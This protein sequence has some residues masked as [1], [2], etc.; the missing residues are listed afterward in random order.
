MEDAAKS[1][2][3]IIFFLFK[4]GVKPSEIVQRLQGVFGESAESKSTVYLW[5]NR[6]KAGRTSLEDDPRSGRP[7]TSVNDRTVVAVE[8]LLKADRRITIREISVSVGIG[9]RQVH[10][11]LHERL[12]V[13]KVSARWVPRL[14]GPEQKLNRSDTCR[15]LQEL[16]ARYGDR[17]WQR[18]ITTD[19]TWIPFF[20]PETKTQSKEWRKPDEGPPLKARAV[21]S[22][23]KV[24]LTVFWDCEGIIC[25]DYLPK[26]TTINAEYYSNVLSGPL[27]QALA[28]KRPGK[29]HKRPLLQQD[30][31]RPHTA[32]RTKEVLNDLRWELL[33]HPP[34]SPDLAPSDYHLFPNMKKPLRGVRFESLN[35][36]K[37]AINRWIAETPKNFFEDGL[38]KLVTRWDKCIQ[39]NGDYIE[40]LSCNFDEN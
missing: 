25:M 16:L 1:Q 29:L 14:L 3:A 39:L 33:P 5:V 12:G 24:M 28:K 8:N 18:I 35:D 27:R 13:N 4:E 19:E 23:G 9:T 30:N 37:R 10:E 36:V 22:V 6:F 7:S 11:I 15:Q 26:G 17:F 2:R 31:A 40:K 32:R 38:K 21:P 20:N 34:Y